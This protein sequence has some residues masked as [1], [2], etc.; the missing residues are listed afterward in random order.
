MTTLKIRK[1]SP[2]Q[3]CWADPSRR[4]L[5]TTKNFASRQ[6]KIPP[7]QTDWAKVELLNKYNGLQLMAILDQQVILKLYAPMTNKISLCQTGRDELEIL[8]KYGVLLNG[9]PPCQTAW[10]KVW[11]VWDHAHHLILSSIMTIPPIINIDDRRCAPM[12]DILSDLLAKIFTI[13]SIHA[14]T[15]QTVDCSVFVLT[16][17]ISES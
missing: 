3:T 7:R 15:W 8:N 1:I 13:I 11:S 5:R 17:Q 12:L 4:L 14:V 9:V 6:N 2:W 16:Y 10:T